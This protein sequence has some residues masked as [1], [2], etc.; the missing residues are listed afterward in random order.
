MEVVPS[1]P[2]PEEAAPPERPLPFSASASHSVSPRVPPV[3]EVPVEVAAL[4]VLVAVVG[5]EEVV[6]AC[7][8][9]RAFSA[10]L[11]GAARE[12][13]RRV[14]RTERRSWKRIL[15]MVGAL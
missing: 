11:R 4:L 8:G 5:V 9:A 6:V 2:Q 13:V 12:V 1:L 15:V 3:V 10:A 7:R 14:A